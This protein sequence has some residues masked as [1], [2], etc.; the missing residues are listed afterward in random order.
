MSNRLTKY[1]TPATAITVGLTLIDKLLPDQVPKP[2][3]SIA[4]PVL[5]VAVLLVTIGWSIR[6]T[7]WLLRAL[8]LPWFPRPAHRVIAW[9]RRRPAITILQ[10]VPH[11]EIENDLLVTCT[12]QLLITRSS[13]RSA[14]PAII[15]LSGAKL[16]CNCEAANRWH[17]FKPRQSG[18]FF[19]MPIASAG[20][21]IRVDFDLIQLPV[22]L[23]DGPDLSTPY[24]LTLTGV[25]GELGGPQPMRGRL[26]KSEWQVQLPD[27]AVFDPATQFSAA[28]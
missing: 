9:L 4:I 5:A 20:D 28:F 19:L 10:A 7:S 11:I 22:P 12:L 21:T 25:V 23:P 15:D 16:R 1:L 24:T 8:P 17:L 14:T 6:G 18:G 26:P 13:T 27:P 2:P 3:A